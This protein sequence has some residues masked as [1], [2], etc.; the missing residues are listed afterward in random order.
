MLTD[1]QKNMIEA[2]E[3]FRHEIKLKL[4]SD[5][6]NMQSTAVDVG[7]A[8]I[9]VE[10]KISSKSIE[11]F[12]SSLGMLLI[13]SVFIS[14]GGALYQQ[15]QQRYEIEQKNKEQLVAYRFEIGDRI[16]NMRYLLRH[17]K[18]VGDAKTALASIFKSK[19]PL[20][21]DLDNK[22]LSALYFNLYQLI[23]GNEQTKSKEAIAIVRDLEDAEYSLQSKNNSDPLDAV[24]K[25]KLTK[26]IKNIERLH[27]DK[28]SN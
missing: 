26:L 18:T 10:K 6:A 3:R 13:S 22:S 15:A 16:Q 1:D 11:F 24:E 28:A 27:I 23:Q 8:V 12:N 14:G 2:E 9:D 4:E 20:N 7:K 17:S 19:F 25:A 5:A 21:S